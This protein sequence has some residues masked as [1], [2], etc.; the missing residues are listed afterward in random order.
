[1]KHDRLASAIKKLPK[2]SGVYIFKRNKI[3]LYVGKA[4]NLKS[5]VSSY[6]KSTD[7][8][9]KK[10]LEEANRIDFEQTESDIKALI[11]ESQYIKR[12]QPKFNVAMRDDKQ[13]LSVAFT[14]E[15]YPRIYLT[16][17]SRSRNLSVSAVTNPQVTLRGKTRKMSE[18]DAEYIGPF[19]DSTALKSTLNSLRRLFPYCTCKQNHHVRCLNAH[20]GKCLGFCCLKDP[21]N[22]RLELYKENIKAIKGILNGNKATVIKELKKEMVALAK[23]HRFEDAI[24]LRSKIGNIERIFQNAQIIKRQQEHFHALVEIQKVLKLKNIPNRIEGYDISNIQGV[25]ATGAM[26]AFIEGRPDKNEYRK[27]KIRQNFSSKNQGGQVYTKKTADSPRGASAKLGDTGMLR[28]VLTRRLNHPEWPYP[29]LIIV[30]GGKGQL[31]AIQ[32][33]LKEAKQDIS[34]IGLT[35]NDKHFGDYVV[36]HV[37]QTYKII[38]LTRLP[39]AVRNLILDVDA[40]AHRF[41]I[42]YYRK[43]HTR[44]ITS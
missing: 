33:V 20:I 21:V 3:P 16:H 36:Y 11:L 10:M 19:T 44:S 34:T 39:P 5:R 25:H 37:D 12:W 30:D 26:I 7:T 1:M 4:T 23:D 27:F 41:A 32:A 28:E 8:R 35:K 6:P 31:N 9:I 40:E 2:T 38:K 22:A 17:Q 24:A 43:L 18:L 15:E 29:D 13:Y 42:G 14:K